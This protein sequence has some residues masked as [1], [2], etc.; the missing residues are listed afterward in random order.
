VG[1]KSPTGVGGTN[2]RP[3]QPP[4]T[5]P[6]PREPK[7]QQQDISKIPARPRQEAAPAFL[8]IPRIDDEFPVADL[9]GATGQGQNIPASTLGERFY[10][11][12]GRFPTETD[13][14]II[15]VRR[16]FEKD[17]GR[18]PT[19]DE[20]LSTLRNN[21]IVNREDEFLG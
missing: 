16:R 2:V 5:E 14:G 11:R 9:V 12:Y 13:L 1:Q 4:P 19:R 8:S 7:P 6:T 20:L 3:N 15:A 21:M 18:P 10:R 17:A